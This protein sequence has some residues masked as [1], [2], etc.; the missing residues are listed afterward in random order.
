MNHHAAFALLDLHAEGRLSPRRAAQVAAHL[1][2]CAE[3]RRL[4]APAERP[5]AAGADGRFKAGLAAALKAAAPSSPAPRAP[6]ELPLLPRDL[7]GVAWAGAALF[8]LALVIGWSGAPSQ[9]YASGDEIVW[10]RTP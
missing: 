10:G 1:A 8:L 5:R 2:S 6:L 4:A 9:G 7:A 3:C